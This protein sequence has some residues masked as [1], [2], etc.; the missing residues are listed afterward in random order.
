M[1]SH[2]QLRQYLKRLLQLH[3]NRQTFRLWGLTKTEHLLQLNERIR[4][5]ADSE[6]QYKIRR[7]L[8]DR[9]REVVREKVLPSHEAKLGH[10]QIT[11]AH[12]I[13]M[14]I[15]IHI[16]RPPSSTVLPP[17]NHSV[18]AIFSAS[19]R[20]AT[21]ASASPSLSARHSHARSSKIPAMS[22]NPRAHVRCPAGYASNTARC[23]I[24]AS[25]YSPLVVWNCSS[26]A[27]SAC[28]YAQPEGGGTMWS[29]M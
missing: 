26:C 3:K 20:N 19:Y 17:K 14:R 7:E 8:T 6:V 16:Y 2:S 9:A 28:R 27:R 4:E 25:R 13:S 23:V 12:I 29:V 11:T 5:Q 22:L 10:S 18:A 1:Y 24:I 15:R 21:A